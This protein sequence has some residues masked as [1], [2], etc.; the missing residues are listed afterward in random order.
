MKIKI[1]IVSQKISKTKLHNDGIRSILTH[2]DYVL[3][4]AEDNK[5]MSYNFNTNYKSIITKTENFI[6][7]IIKFEDKIYTAGF[8]GVI[9]VISL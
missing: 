2:K 1:D 5:V 4:C 6:Q 9:S 8:N 3:T 7:D